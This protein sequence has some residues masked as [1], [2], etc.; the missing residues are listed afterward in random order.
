MGTG[1][2]AGLGRHSLEGQSVRLLAV[3][4]TPSTG[5]MKEALM[6]SVGLAVTA[7]YWD[8]QYRVRLERAT[9]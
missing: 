6:H 1:W 7:L 8:A 3:M 2:E 9:V 4:I 5:M